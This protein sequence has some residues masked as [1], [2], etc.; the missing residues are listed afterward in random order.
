[1][2]FKN[3]LLLTFSFC[4]NLVIGQNTLPELTLNWSANEQFCSFVQTRVPVQINGNFNSDNKF[5]V[6]LADPGSNKT[7]ANYDAKLENGHLVFTI[8]DTRPDSHGSL[9]LSVSSTS[10]VT[11]SNTIWKS[12]YSRGE[13]SAPWVVSD[14]LN[15]GAGFD[16]KMY[17]TSNDL[18]KM[19][20]SDGSVHDV[21]RS[22]SP[23]AI[24]MTASRAEDV[25][26]LSAVNRCGVA[27]PV[28]GKVPIKINPIS[29]IPT[30]I[31]NATLCEGSEMELRYDVMGGVIPE[32]ATFK[33][34]FLTDAYSHNKA[35]TFEIPARSKSPGLLTARIPDDILEYSK[36]YQVAIVVDGPRLLSSYS[37]PFTVYEKPGASLSSQSDSVRAGAPFTMRFKIS[38]PEPY[39]IE[40][41]NG[42][43]QHIDQ[44][45]TMVQYPTKTTT[46]SISSLKTGCGVTTDFPKQNVIAMVPAG[47][48]ITLPSD[49][50]WDICENQKVRLPFL[51][52]VPLNANTVFTVEGRTYKNTTYQFEAKVVNDSVEFLI[53][54]SPAEWADE[55]HYNINEFRI[56][57][58]NPTLTSDYRYGF[59]VR[60]IPRIAYTTYQPRTLP[61]SQDYTYV[62]RLSGGRP[63][64]VTDGS[65]NKKYMDWSESEER[66]FVNESGNFGPKTVENT[67]YVNNDLPKLELTINPPAFQSPAIVIYPP[68][69]KFY[70]EQDSVE[71]SFASLGEFGSG[72][73]FQIFGDGSSEP[74]LTVSSPGRYKLPVS[75]LRQ[76]IYTYIGIRSTNPQISQGSNLPIMMDAKPVLA[77][78]GD[79]SGG[80]AQ[81]P[82]IFEMDQIPAVYVQ[83]KSLS[84]YSAEFSDGTKTYHFQQRLA[85]DAFRPPMKRSTVETYTLKSLTNVCGTTEM[86]LNSFLYWKAYTLSMKYFKTGQVYC[87]G[88]EMEVPFNVSGGSLPNGATFYLQVMQ[89]TNDFQTI[90]SN[91]TGAAFKFIIPDSMEGEYFIR[92][93]TDGHIQTGTSSFIVNKK[94]TATISSSNPGEIEYGQSLGLNYTLTGGGPWNLIVQGNGETRVTNPNYEHY[95]QPNRSTLFQL[96]SVSNQCGYGTVSGSVPV[97]VKVKI[98]TLAPDESIVCSG[99]SINVKYHVAGDIPTGQRIGFYLTNASGSR[100]ELPFVSELTGTL[101]VPISENLLSGFYNITCYISGTDV[102]LSRSIQVAKAPDIE[103]SGTTTMNS[104]E[105]T[106]LNFRTVNGGD[107]M[108]RVTL[109][110]GT[111]EALSMFDPKTGYNM[112]VAPAVT[113][114]Y[115]IA[116]AVSSCGVV[117]ASGSAVVVVNP[118]SERTIAAFALSKYT[119]CEKDT[120]LVYY[121]HKGTFSSGNQ[122]SVQVFNSRGGL[123]NTLPAAGKTSPLQVVIP[124]GF[125]VLEGYRIRIVATDANTASGD[126][127]MMLW[128]GLKPAASFANN[129][130][131]LDDKGTAQVVVLLTGTGPWRYSYG[132]DLG[133]IYMS[134]NVAPDTIM[135]KS[136]E[137]SAYFKLLSVSN[138]CGVGVISEPSLIKVEVVLAVEDPIGAANVS[139]GP[140]PTDGRVTI[141]FKNSAKRQLTMHS[142]SGVPMW[143]KVSSELEEAIELERYP[144]GVYLLQIEHNGNRQ[145]FKIMKN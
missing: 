65:G 137:P 76:Q 116:S 9:Q 23:I 139:F 142:L 100:F 48:V 73:K 81:Q 79:F 69:S 11:K 68:T 122:F 71:I 85:S 136:N 19:T 43:S 135:I 42:A 78:P 95:V 47:I 121:T 106:Y 7:I 114:T 27:V 52:N 12:F 66:I 28:L 131:S 124:T 8:A 60:G 67:C 35:T 14:T 36:T 24:R 127:P 51:A 112:K 64:D 108:I 107:L 144:S 54:H 17:V 74:W 82:R 133:Q 45:F 126:Y 105:Q 101:S 70:C 117:K 113:T 41:N 128:S 138:A 37:D 145:S 94:P 50:K 29:I 115:T 63:Y 56:K 80:T 125:S 77:Y 15:S 75:V 134:S 88:E 10:P 141:R 2:K 39:T 6:E 119:L 16:L 111:T 3:L 99:N 90:A 89:G 87:V 55:G 40:L 5:I 130:V 38:G 1:M 84:P 32:S 62:L 96:Q 102:S 18:V 120:L 25:F 83:A 109:S 59:T 110:D 98:V 4:Y 86:N 118:P 104:G 93:T 34:R 132:N 26:V 30:K 57:T 61:H 58:T 140:N 20:M 31:V 72:N 13:I 44:N 143:N 22:S 21:Y 97:T 123:V 53:P 92:V 49:H 46:Y 103:L 129:Y 91:T 33:L